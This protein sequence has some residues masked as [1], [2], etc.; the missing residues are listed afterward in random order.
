[1]KMA[2]ADLRVLDI[3][4]SKVRALSDYNPNAEIKPTVILW[5]DKDCRFEKSIPNIQKSLPEL[6]VLGDYN[7]EKKT[8]PAIW[9]RCV[10]AGT[11]ETTIPEGKTPII[12]MPGIGRDRFRP[13]T[14]DS[15]LK[16]LIPLQYTGRFFSQ[17][18]FRDI[19]P[20]SFLAKT[21]E[22]LGLDIPE[23]SELRE[24][25]KSALP[26]ILDMSLS[27][28]D[29][30]H[31]DTD[32][33]NSIL[34]GG[35]TI[36]SLLR[37]INS[38]EASF[39]NPEQREALRKLFNS[40]YKL[41][42][43]KDSQ[44][45]AAEKLAKHDNHEWQLVWDRYQKS[46]NSYK[47]IEKQI[48]SCYHEPLVLTVEYMKSEEG[49]PQYNDQ[50]EELL[51]NR[52]NDLLTEPEDTVIKEIEYL[53]HIHSARIE[54]V[55]GKHGGSQ[56]ARATS[57]FNEICKL[58]K[59]EGYGSS[60]QELKDYYEKTGYKIDMYA[61]LAL[62]LFKEDG[63]S[64][65]VKN[66]LSTFYNNH[67]DKLAN[68]FQN[69][70]SAEGYPYKA[71]TDKYKKN[72]CIL[73]VDGLRYDMAQ[74]LKERIEDDESIDCSI[75]CNSFWCPFPSVTACGKYSISPIVSELQ[76][77]ECGDYGPAFKDTGSQ[78][79]ATSFKK[80][81]ES[82]GWQII[83]DASIKDSEYGWYATRSID[84]LGHQKQCAMAQLLEELIDEVKEKIQE[85]LVAGWVHVLV[86]TDHGWLLVPNKMPKCELPKSMTE[87]NGGRCAKMIPGVKCEYQ[88]VPW[89]W[90]DEHLVAAARGVG[91]FLD[92]KEY[93]H[94]GLSLEECLTAQLTI[95]SVE[96]ESITQIEDITWK[97]MACSFDVK[98][99][100]ENLIVDIRFAPSDESTSIVANAK[101]P[102]IDGHA[103]LLVVNDDAEGKN[104]YV[105]VLSKSE[106]TVL[107]QKSI[108]IGG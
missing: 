8:G 72:T 98:G 44:L 26:V 7:P 86:V 62:S 101:Q 63:K 71:K 92:G 28:L 106:K 59:S 80:K 37:Y 46:Y 84:E 20:Y 97:G 21:N 19:T 107:Y 23:G 87:S 75:E 57:Y 88:Q 83:T 66:V 22:G 64:N 11:V 99:D 15:L 14:A 16:P 42:I 53:D 78:I 1:M 31:I 41:N 45:S 35:D 81:L 108:V 70:V 27:E 39:K 3:L 52:L 67:I 61:L 33:L 49:W 103:R 24:T 82:M 38:G 18:S 85:L 60:V 40:K 30:V 12:Y 104:A 90:N 2:D 91:S 102:D 58:I 69:A 95:S 76:G 56:M 29:G 36:D 54:T 93:A 55:W 47:N 74:M 77:Q 9:L 34:S 25:L 32:Y 5:P 13:D 73:F 79:N 48:R 43:D 89:S 65:L 10:I 105:V 50:M 51:T 68:A 96:N 4:T 6:L 100:I 94:G 17:R